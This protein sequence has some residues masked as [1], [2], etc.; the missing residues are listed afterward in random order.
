MKNN[1]RLLK[2]LKKLLEDESIDVWME[3]EVHF[4]LAGSRCHMWIPPEVKDPVVRHHPTRKHIGYFG[5]VRIR[6]G[7]MVYQKT[8]DSF[9][10]ETC[11]S[12]FRKLK[13]QSVRS[14]RRVIIVLDN[15]KYHHARL[16]KEWRENN[17]KRF[18]CVFLPAYSPEFNTIERVWKLTRRRSI[19]NRYFFSLGDIETAVESQF[20]QWKKSN[21]TLNQLCAFN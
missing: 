21:K 19:H 1:K 20:Q 17:E 14:G 10:A 16:H 11:F 12:F 15:A 3:D 13:N 5:A 6:D 4:Y 8:N 2:K 18:S 9:N 7:K